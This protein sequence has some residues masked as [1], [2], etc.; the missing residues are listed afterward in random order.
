MFLIKQTNEWYQ[1]SIS[2]IL[3]DATRNAYEY[4]MNPYYSGI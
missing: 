3:L 1:K 4:F 2:D